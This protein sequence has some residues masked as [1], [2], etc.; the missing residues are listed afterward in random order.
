M[1]GE[2]EA[3]KAPR[4]FPIGK[5][6]EGGAELITTAHIRAYAAATNETNPRY[7]SE[8]PVA[9]PIFHMRSFRD[10]MFDVILDPELELDVL[11]LLHGEHHA[12]F[13]GQIHAGDRLHRQAILESVTEKSSGILV[14][15]RFE[16]RVQDQ[17]VLHAR[18][19]FFVRAPA[20]RREKSRETPPPPHVRSNPT[21]VE[22]LQISEDQSWRYAEASLDVNPIHVDREVAQ[23]AGFADVILQGLCTMAMTG[24]VI[25]DRLLHGDSTKLSSLGV[26]FIRPVSNGVTLKVHVLERS[27]GTVEFETLSLDGDTVH[28][29]GTATL[30]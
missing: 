18:S 4:S 28:L 20:A 6:W 1:S 23:A 16:G 17:L 3:T 12:S 5:I 8:N 15:V 30:Q 29:N 14:S 2:N 9:S 26:R 13:P 24:R 10:L 19:S 27:D 25:V 11:R 21:W 22:T 7:F